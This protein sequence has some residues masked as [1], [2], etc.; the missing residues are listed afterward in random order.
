MKYFLLSTL[1]FFDF[2][3]CVACSCEKLQKISSSEVENASHIF[4]GRVIKSA[5]FEQGRQFTFHVTTKLK[6]GIADTVEIRTGFGGSDCGLNMQD[7]QEWY[8]FAYD[9]EGK[10][11]SGLCGRSALLSGIPSH[12]T[13]INKEYRRAELRSYN[14]NKRR[15]LKEIKFI[16]KFTG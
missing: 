15:A 3:I 14:T 1:S 8:I 2:T 16:R 13:T 5:V 4:I 11:W 6:P 7:G 12:G 9:G 10:H